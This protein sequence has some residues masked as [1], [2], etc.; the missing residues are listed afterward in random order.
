MKFVEKFVVIPFE[1]YQRLIKD[2]NSIEDSDK[3]LDKDSNK[4]KI[5][6]IHNSEIK[7]EN[8]KEVNIVK[9][10][11]NKKGDPSQKFDKKLSESV[12]IPHRPPGI[13]NKSKKT[14]FKWE[15]LF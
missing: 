2:K 11:T 8:K 1:R 5:E 7:G 3:D 15:A 9:T 6:D 14:S 4:E 12:T 10:E 13:P